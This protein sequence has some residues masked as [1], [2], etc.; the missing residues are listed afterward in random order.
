MYVKLKHVHSAPVQQASTTPSSSNWRT[1]AAAMHIT[2][3]MYHTKI[4]TQLLHSTHLGSKTVLLSNMFQVRDFA[5]LQGL[6]LFADKKGST[7]GRFRLTGAGFCCVG[8]FAG[9]L[10]LGGEGDGL[11][12]VG[13]LV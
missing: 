1:V 9:L 10:S 2:C 4:T 6:L 8:C 13:R 5:S 12:A 3:S 7:A 11:V